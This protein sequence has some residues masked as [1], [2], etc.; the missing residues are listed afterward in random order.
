MARGT[1][2]SFLPL[3]VSD[4]LRCDACQCPACL[5]DP[6]L[7]GGRAKLMPGLTTKTSVR[8][9]YITTAALHGA[10][11]GTIIL[12]GGISVSLLT[13]RIQAK[14]NIVIIMCL[15]SGSYSLSPFTNRGWIINVIN[16][17]F[18]PLHLST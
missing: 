11:K 12:V 1:S 2:C 14:V 6:L 15:S 7:I 16:I 4:A 13:R 9:P 3:D 17:T 18:T 8:Q 5:S 10:G